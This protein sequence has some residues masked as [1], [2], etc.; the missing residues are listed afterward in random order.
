[1][2]APLPRSRVRP[3]RPFSDTGVDLGGPL[4]VRGT[5]LQKDKL[6][7]AVFTCAATRALHLEVVSSLK[8]EDFVKAYR[9]FGARR[10]KPLS[11]L[12]DSAKTFERAAT[13]GNRGSVLAVHC[14]AGFLV[15]RILGAVDRTD[16]VGSAQNA[17]KSDAQQRRAGNSAV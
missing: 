13:L 8:T 4:F 5:T 9:R 7:F 15:G 16:Q 1:M 3:T 2:T 14:R 17:T 6:Y 12:S 10:A 11:I